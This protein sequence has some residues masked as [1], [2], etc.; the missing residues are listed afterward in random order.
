MTD[1]RHALIIIDLQNDYFPEG[2]FPLWNTVP[3]LDKTIDA[4]KLADA[5][6]IPVILI[7]HIAPS[8]SPFF[9]EGTSGAELHPRLLAA[10]PTAPIVIK[11]QADSF[12]GTTLTETL[13]TLKVDSLLIC[14]M[15]THNCVTHTALSKAAEK[16]QLAILQDCCTT[17]S[18]ILHVIALKAIEPRVSL[19]TSEQVLGAVSH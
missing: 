12:L 5:R 11:T 2:K 1:P 10:A 13:D 17:V 19:R 9:C 15:M 8:Q 6:N 4:I 3:V 14:G 18:E 16:Y 7:Q